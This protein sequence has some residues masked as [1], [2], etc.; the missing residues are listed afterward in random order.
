MNKRIELGLLYSR[1]GSYALISEACRTGALNAIAEINADPAI[2]LTFAPIERDPGGN[3]DAYAPLCEEILRDSGARHVIG[4]VTSWSRKEVIPVLEK[5]GGTLWYAIPYEGFEASDH[6]VYTHG[7][8]NQHLLPLLGWAFARRGRRS[9]LIGSNYI[10]GWEMNRLAREVICAAGGEV[11]GERYLQLGSL[12]IDRMIAE[13]RATRPDF[14]LNNLIGPSQ[15]AFLAA[16]HRL[17]EED[18]YFHAETCPILSCNLTE[19]EMPAILPAA[20]EGLVAA[21][22]YFRGAPGWPEGA[23]RGFGSSHEAAAW[24]AVHRLARLLSGH[25]GAETQGLSRLLAEAPGGP[26]G[27]DLATHHTALP[28]RIAQYERGAFAIR[29]DVG[30]VAGDPYLAHGR[31][32]AVPRPPRL[33]VVS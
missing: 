15:Y 17:G 27:I 24:S 2:P 32:G 23:A 29:E 4:C 26:E 25:E 8:P 1:S 9:F 3:I 5:F 31:G 6:I 28:V 33:R 11:L 30:T 21:G 7:C 13:I 22:P 20:A 18:P 10:W 16:Y 12:E 14:V 19:C